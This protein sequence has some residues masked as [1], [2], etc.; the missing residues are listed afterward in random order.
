MILQ[1]IQILLVSLIGTKNNGPVHDLRKKQ[2]PVDFK[3]AM[4][5]WFQMNLGII[6]IIVFIVGIISLVAFCFLV[7]GTGVESG[8]WY[9]HMSEVI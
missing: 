8:I 3:G 5:E 2:T 6:C 1:L 4:G 9:N 7:I